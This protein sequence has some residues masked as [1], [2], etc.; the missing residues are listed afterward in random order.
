[1]CCGRIRSSGNSMVNMN[2]YDIGRKI[3]RDEAEVICDMH[4][5][6]SCALYDPIN[7]SQEVKHLLFCQKVRRCAK[8]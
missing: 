2:P 4:D 6:I 5:E 7:P 8:S 1:M 3:T